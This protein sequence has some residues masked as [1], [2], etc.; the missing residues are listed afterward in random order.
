MMKVTEFTPS[1]KSLSILLKK[2]DIDAKNDAKII[3]KAFMFDPKTNMIERAKLSARLMSDLWELNMGS[4]NYEE[5]AAYSKA[6]FKNL[7]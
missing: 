2:V 3:G 6:L 1:N 4:V 5:G 7:S